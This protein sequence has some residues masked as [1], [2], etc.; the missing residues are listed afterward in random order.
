MN[1]A[2]RTAK[3]RGLLL[4]LSG[5]GTLALFS[6]PAQANPPVTVSCG[7]TLTHSVKLANDLSNCPSD[8]LVVGADNV[9]VDLNGH[10]IDG[11]VSKTFDCEVGPQGPSGEG[12]QDDAG[13]DGV[14]IKGG[15][16]QQFANGVRSFNESETVA[17]PTVA[18]SASPFATTA[19]RASS[20]AEAADHQTTTT[21]STTTWSCVTATY[22]ISDWA[23]LCTRPS[24]T[25]TTTE[26]KAA[27]TASLPAAKATTGT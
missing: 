23:S 20:S 4:M 17:I 9:T 19:T 6:A 13:Y 14:T 12:I 18:C 24:T 15:T 26:F 21:E 3:C 22:A 2:T 1:K 7:Q 27:A 11:V 25:S 5:L 16:V 10:T 8:G